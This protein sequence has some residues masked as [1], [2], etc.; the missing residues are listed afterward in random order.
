MH[1]IPFFSVLDVLLCD[2]GIMIAY[3]A[4]HACI[5]AGIFRF[6]LYGVIFIM[7]GTFI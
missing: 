5:T 2:R 6:G 3:P 4:R 1:S 7:N